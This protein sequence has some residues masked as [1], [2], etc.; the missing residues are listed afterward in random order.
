MSEPERDERAEWA[1]LLIR[2]ETAERRVQELEGALRERRIKLEL[3][4]ETGQR[5][6]IELDADSP[7]Q[8]LVSPPPSAMKYGVLRLLVDKGMK[9]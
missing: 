6:I 2:T 3:G 7:E 8:L 4:H 1:S 5:E 9:G